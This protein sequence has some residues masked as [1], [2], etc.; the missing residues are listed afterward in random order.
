MHHHLLD[1]HQRTQGRWPSR[2]QACADRLEGECHLGSCLP[3][4]WT[5]WYKPMQRSVNL[6]VN[7]HVTTPNSGVSFPGT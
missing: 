3:S 2:H 5:G 6:K 4:L 1:K 7:A